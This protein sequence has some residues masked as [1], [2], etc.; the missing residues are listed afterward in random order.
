MKIICLVI[1]QLYVYGVE[2][3]WVVQKLD[4]KMRKSR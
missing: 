1:F 3:D 2:T 4:K